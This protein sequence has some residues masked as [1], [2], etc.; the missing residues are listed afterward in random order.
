MTPQGGL[1]PLTYKT[2]F[3]LIAATGLRVSEALKLRLADLDLP[4]ATLT[5]RQTKFHKSRSL[6]VRS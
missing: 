4:G 3:G 2:L 1:R 5:V 6:P